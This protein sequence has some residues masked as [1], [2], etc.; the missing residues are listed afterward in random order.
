MKKNMWH[1]VWKA[2]QVLAVVF[3]LLL[4]TGCTA[5]SVETPA[6][7][8]TGVTGEI[9]VYAAASL[10]DAFTEIG[11]AFEAANPGTTVVFNFGGSSQ[12]AAQ[13]VEG[14]PGDVFAS[15]ND[16]QMQVVVDAGLVTATPTMFLSNRLVVV[17]PVDNPAGV[18]RLE[19]L[20]NPGILLVLAVPGVPVRDY[21]DEI[22]AG[23]GSDFSSAFYTNLVSEEDNVR[24]VAAK[25]ALGEADAGIVYR[26]D[27]T[28]DIQAQV[29][30]ID[31]PDEQNVIATYPIAPVADADNP[32][33]AD[34]FVAF[35]LSAEGQAILANWGFGAPP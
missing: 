5:P 15:A 16:R 31:I 33:G 21:T 34:A 1:R 25:V 4:A 14:A 2:G 30:K 28:P 3:V 29:V 18:T 22:V 9:L 6:A 35:V 12:L 27:V 20:A 17:T 24:Q 19:D 32:A 13:L 7:E 10:T 8:T 11:A 26:S 23:L